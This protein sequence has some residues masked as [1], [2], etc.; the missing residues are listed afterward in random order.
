MAEKP[1]AASEIILELPENKGESTQQLKAVPVSSGSTVVQE[2]PTVT[3]LLQRKKL[4]ATMSPNLA[5]LKTENEFLTVTP[6]RRR[7]SQTTISSA[8]VS[9]PNQPPAF[10]GTLILESLDLKKFQKM[11]LWVSH[12]L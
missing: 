1:K 2:M 12:I 11:L 10:T 7:T 6:A 9:L 8:A 3:T 4:S 5:T